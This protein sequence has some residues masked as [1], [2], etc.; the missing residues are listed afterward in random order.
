MTEY[1][2]CLKSVKTDRGMEPCGQALV[3]RTCPVHGFIFDLKDMSAPDAGIRDAAESEQ[4]DAR[5]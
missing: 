2:Y 4:G 1:G 3:G 5:S